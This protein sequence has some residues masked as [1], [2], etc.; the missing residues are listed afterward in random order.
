ML[1]HCYRMLGSAHDAGDVIHETYL[2]AWR[3]YKDFESRSSLRTWLYRIAT[4]ACLTALA[5]RS[6]RVLPSGLGVPADDPQT[7]PVPCA[8]RGL[9]ASDSGRPGEH[10][11]RP[12]GAR[13]VPGEPA[14]GVGGEPATSSG[15]AARG[16]APAG[17]D[18]FPAVE[19]AAMPDV[20][21]TAV[22]SAL[23]RARARMKDV[24]PSL[25]RAGDGRFANLVRRRRHLPAMSRR[26]KAWAAR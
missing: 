25:R 26:R 24:A 3:G 6:R 14:P 20:S 2:R 1:A 10:R 13:R 7:E 11:R 15:S 22:K 21:V 16:A 17:R 8:R 9:A 12:G 5:H 23:Q 19:V 4:N 18:A